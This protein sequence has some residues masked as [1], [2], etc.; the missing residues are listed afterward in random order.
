MGAELRLS[1]GTGRSLSK[2]VVAALSV[3]ATL[4]LAPAAFYGGVAYGSHSTTPQSAAMDLVVQKDVIESEPKMQNCAATWG[5]LHGEQMLHDF[6]RKVLAHQRHNSKVFEVVPRWQLMGGKTRVRF[7]ACL[8]DQGQLHLLLRSACCE[9]GQWHHRREG[10]R[11]PLGPAQEQCWPVCLQR[12]GGLQRPARAAV[13]DHQ[14]KSR[15]SQRGVWQVLQERQAGSLHQHAPLLRSLEIAQGWRQVGGHVL[16][17]EGGCAN[18]LHARQAA[19]HLGHQKKTIRLVS[20]SR[21]ARRFW[22]DSSATWR[23]SPLK[24][25]SGSWSRWMHPSRPGA[26]GRTLRRAKR[27]GS[28]ALGERTSS[29][30]GPWTMPKSPRLASSPCTVAA[31]ARATGRR[32]RRRTPSLCPLAILV[33]PKLPSIHSATSNHGSNALAPLPAS[34]TVRSWSERWDVAFFFAQKRSGQ[35][36]FPVSRPCLIHFR[37]TVP[38]DGHN[39]VMSQKGPHIGVV[40]EKRTGIIVFVH[41]SSLMPTNISVPTMCVL[42]RWMEQS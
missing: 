2:R 15:P 21:T 3:G 19:H 1:E 5:K 11:D 33:R 41:V 22:R 28:T 34:S 26:G 40:E 31:L 12:L 7:Q 17:G 8:H 27:V 37:L 6:R 35:A 18:G 32:T 23:W 38:Y 9:A 4:L 25:S 42:H 20:I 39:G 10:P 30:R 16:G 13:P 14:Y 29:C 36:K 24:V